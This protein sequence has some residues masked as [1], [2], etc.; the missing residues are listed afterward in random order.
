MA[1]V[2]RIHVKLHEDFYTEIVLSTGLSLGITGVCD[3]SL[4]TSLSLGPKRV[5]L[6]FR[7]MLTPG[8]YSSHLPQLR[9]NLAIVRYLVAE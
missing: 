6:C 3:V 2:R 7:Q 4:E 1:F 5:E 9:K 8:T